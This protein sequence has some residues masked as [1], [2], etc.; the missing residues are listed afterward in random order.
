[1]HQRLKGILFGFILPPPEGYP[2][3]RCLSHQTKLVNLLLPLGTPSHIHKRTLALQPKTPRPRRAPSA[4][5]TWRLSA[6]PTLSPRA[7][8]SQAAQA[9][10]RRQQGARGILIWGPF[11]GPSKK[12]WELM[13][14]PFG[15]ALKMKFAMHENE[16]AP[17]FGIC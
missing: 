16:S 11:L 2:S 15:A 14:K 4:L 5:S 8:A 13:E 1:M 9:S 6:R 12:T 3:G 10:V 17:S 7:S